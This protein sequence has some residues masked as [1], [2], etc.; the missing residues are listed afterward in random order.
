M[1]KQ[2][3]KLDPYREENHRLLIRCYGEQGE[4]GKIQTHFRYLLRLF[5]EELAV[6]PSRETM[7]LVNSLLK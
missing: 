7:S 3:L 2:A 6:E 5:D 1:F 4:R